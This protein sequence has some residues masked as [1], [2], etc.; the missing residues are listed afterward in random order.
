MAADFDGFGE[1]FTLSLPLDG[2]GGA[3]VPF[4]FNS[5]HSGRRYP[6]SFHAMTRL[7]NLSIRK[8]EDYLVDELFADVVA[9]GAPLLA[10]NF[11]RAW[12]DVNREPYELD[13]VMF[14]EAL[15]AF[16]N[17]RSVRVSGGLGTIARIVSEREEIYNRKLTV[18]EGLERIERY[19]K[20]YHERLRTLLAKAI[21]RFGHAVLVDCHS[22]PSASAFSRRARNW[23]ARADFVVGDR[24]GSSCSPALTH[25][26]TDF[27]K[28]RGYRVA[29]NK[30][31]AGGFITSHYGRPGHGLH[32][33][34]IEVNRGLYM[35]EV[36]M[37]KSSGFD[38]LRRDLT[39]LAEHMI[40][41]PSADLAGETPLAAE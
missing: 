8:S 35:D 22:M 20:P 9:L 37:R 14:S 5:P 34:Q 36:R 39:D 40:S 7:D 18:A 27:L 26:A 33:I 6:P 12:L 29:L 15:P 28:G 1:P 19:Y 30:P 25:A 32:A 10:A 2:A 31:Y 17:T 11:P 41:L 21:A 24:Y 13:P 3:R 16:A 4:V 23:S 38:R